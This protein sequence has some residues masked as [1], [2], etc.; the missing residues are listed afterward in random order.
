MT[1]FSGK[2][3]KQKKVKN[4]LLAVTVDWDIYWWV[5]ETSKVKNVRAQRE[6][7]RDRKRYYREV[8]LRESDSN[9]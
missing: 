4:L 9:R 1:K 2:K 8:K 6:I 3:K 5:G 7:D